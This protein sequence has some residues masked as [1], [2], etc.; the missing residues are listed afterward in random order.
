MRTYVRGGIVIERYEGCRGI[1]LDQGELERLI[2]VEGAG[3]SGIV[4][5][6]IDPPGWIWTAGMPA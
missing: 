6:R 3:R 1:H 2:D 4:G 5:E